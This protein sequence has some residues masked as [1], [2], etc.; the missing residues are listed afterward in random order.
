MMQL[1]YAHNTLSVM[2]SAVNTIERAYLVFKEK[3]EFSLST[4]QT[5]VSQLG[6]SQLEQQYPHSK[7]W[8]LSWIPK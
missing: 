6:S 4:L 5:F 7:G 2:G 8:T 1:D 3:E